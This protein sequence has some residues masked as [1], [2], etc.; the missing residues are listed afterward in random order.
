MIKTVL[1]PTDFSMNSIHS[2][3]Y[4]LKLFQGQDMK[5]DVIHVGGQLNEDES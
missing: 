5:F 1:F 4:G 2:I 3:L